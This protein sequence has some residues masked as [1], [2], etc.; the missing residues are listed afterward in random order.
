M[1]PDAPGTYVLILRL[2]QAS[3]VACGRLGALALAA[4]WYAYVGSARGPG[5]LAARI[6]HH[7]RRARRPHW[8]IDHLRAVAEVVAVWWAP[9][10]PRLECAWAAALAGLPGAA[11]PGAGFGAS[12]CRCVGHLVALPGPPRASALSAALG[13]DGGLHVLDLHTN[14]PD[15]R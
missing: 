13:Q 3:S 7:L 10:S 11:R 12:D 5:G 9:G 4:G 8:H 15:A 2:P 14:A 6:G 1:L